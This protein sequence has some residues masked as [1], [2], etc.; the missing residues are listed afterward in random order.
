M[1][2][3]YRK[4]EAW[5]QTIRKRTDFVPETGLVLGSGL[6][7]LA[8]K[9][10]VA[11]EVP[12]GELP[13]FPV[14]TVA[15][16]EGKFVFGFAGEAPVAVMQGRVHYYEGYSMEDVVAPI[17]VLGM[18]GAKKLFLTNAA[19]G[20]DKSFRPGDLML[21][22]DHI[23]VL[24]P[25]PLRGENLDELGPRFPDMSQV[26]DPDLRAAVLQAADSL[27]MELRRGVYVQCRGPQYET[28]SEI[29]FLRSMGA[30]AV[31]MS[32]V[33]EAIAAR[34][35][36]LRVCGISCITNMASGIL[37][38][39]LDHNEVQRVAGLARERFEKLVLESV[40]AFHQL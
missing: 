37:S 2:G 15:G 40:S 34:H 38:Q 29:R 3:I 7:E 16:H 25:S 4:L 31:G 14:S 20:I 12:Y 9:I 36:G 35:I 17:R 19:G 23:S 22:E 32:T 30:S 11:A 24:I 18:L 27:G 13:G 10:Q 8:R 1:S 39:P 33:C 5:V 6:G 26:Y 28:P 21:I